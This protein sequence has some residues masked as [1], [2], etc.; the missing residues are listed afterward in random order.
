MIAH[1]RESGTL[2]NIF[3]IDVTVPFRTEL[4]E[5]GRSGLGA[6]VA[7]VA[8]RFADAA[9]ADALQVV[10]LELLHA[11]AVPVVEVARLLALVD[12]PSARVVERESRRAGAAERSFR[13]DADTAAFADARVQVAL[14]HVRASFAVDLCV[15]DRTVALDRV[16]HLARAAPRQ[17]DGATAF[18]FECHARQVVFAATVND[19]GPARPFPV[20]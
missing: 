11:D 14:V 2:V 13:V 18:G 15:T 6:R 17:A 5:G 12:A 4:F 7:I 16:A 10:A 3:S 8:P 19:F 20:V 1:I 9:T